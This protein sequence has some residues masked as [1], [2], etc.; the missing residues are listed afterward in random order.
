MAAAVV[1]V[2]IFCISGTPIW[3]PPSHSSMHV[4]LSNTIYIDI[5]NIRRRCLLVPPPLDHRSPVKEDQTK[6]SQLRFPLSAKI[7]QSMEA[8]VV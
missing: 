1:E 8:L 6:P 7:S 4:V 3:E 2:L 5:Q